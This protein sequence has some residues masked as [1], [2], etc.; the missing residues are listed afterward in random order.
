MALDAAELAH[1]LARDAEAVCRHYLSNGRREG[2]YW[3]VGDV[4]NTPGR[5]LFVRLK[6]P[7]SG[8][9]AAGKWTDAATGDHGDLLD[10]I[11]ESCGLVEFRDVANEAR[12]FLSLPKSEPEPGH[13]RLPSSAPAGSPESARRL[14]AMAQPISGTVVEA[15]LRKRGITALHGTASLRFH[16]RCYYR[17]DAWSPTETWPAMIA[18]V[19][20][21][22]GKITGAHRTWLDPS[23]RDKAA[24][25]T[26]RRAMGALLGNAV[27]FDVARD[28]LAAGEGIE[29]MLSLRCVMPTMPMV[30]AL[31]AAHLAAILF[32]ATLRRLYIAR[33]DDPAGDG[34]MAS[35]IDRANEAGIEAIAL[36]PRL[37]DFNEDLRTL[38]IDALRAAVRVQIAPE[39]VARF[40]ELA[41]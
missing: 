38:G 25:D 20:D 23:G 34:A 24:I 6:G 10:V 1:R 4:R 12:H 41:A 35:L 36:S 39:D 21:P 19:T 29:T 37:G 27:R 33:D 22:G 32:P 26:P 15:Y 7:E 9:G 3:L 11:R 17:P 28:V 16:P 18:A 8:K 31:S 30:A 5:S 14:F 2:H 40:M 13:G